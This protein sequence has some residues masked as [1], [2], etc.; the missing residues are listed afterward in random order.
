MLSSTVKAWVL[1]L[2]IAFGGIA[3]PQR[4][5]AGA[6][7]S[8]SASTQRAR[9]H[10]LAGKRAFEAKRYEAALKEFESGYAIDPRPGFLL[11]MGHA[12]R[13]MGDLRRARDYYLKFLESDPPASERRTTIALVVE[14]D[15][16][17]AA[18]PTSG[19][20]ASAV[21]AP[22]VAPP[23]AVEVVAAPAP[24][25]PPLAPATLV[26]AAVAEE[27]AAPAATESP[28]PRLHLEP[29]VAVRVTSHAEIARSELLVAPSV[30]REERSPPIYRRWWFWAGAGAAAGV[31]AALT[32]GALGSGSSARDSGSWGQ[33]RL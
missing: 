7:N 2:S 8:S 31:A 12:S 16:Q 26:V 29:A 14:I 6:H 23:P 33:I 24:V 28:R 21:P 32:V 4:V 25:E 17:L 9:R 30:A 15:R 5:V 22:A 13:R 11:N 3:L 18:A 19:T 27:P 20:H 10:F 1:G